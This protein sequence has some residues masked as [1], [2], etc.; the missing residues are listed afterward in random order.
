[1]NRFIPVN[2]VTVTLVVETMQSTRKR[3]ASAIHVFVALPEK[4]PPPL[5]LLA[6]SFVCIANVLP[7]V[8]EGDDEGVAEI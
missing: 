5:S 3:I 4:N 8:E 1:M 6:G 2:R 7:S